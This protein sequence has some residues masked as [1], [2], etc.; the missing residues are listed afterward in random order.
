MLKLCDTGVAAL[1]VEFPFCD[2]VTV[3]LPQTEHRIV[4]ARATDD[5]GEI[6]VTSTHVHAGDHH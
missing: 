2:E 6:G 3:Q 1:Y 4:T 5:G